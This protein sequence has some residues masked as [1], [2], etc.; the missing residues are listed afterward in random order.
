MTHAAYVVRDLCAA[1]RALRATNH[2]ASMP[3]IKQ[4]ADK[5]AYDGDADERPALLAQI[6]RA[7]RGQVEP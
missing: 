1:L 6:D 7:M 2:W 5:T 3:T 4:L